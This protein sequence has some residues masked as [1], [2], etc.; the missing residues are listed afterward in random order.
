MYP[1]P[2]VT[3]GF[4]VGRSP[5]P[6]NFIVAYGITVLPTAIAGVALYGV[7]HS[8]FYLFHDTHMIGKAVLRAGAALVIPIKVDDVAG[9]WLVTVVLP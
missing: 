2:E 5:V 4:L 8:V 9:A 7:D 1:P 6:I 3:A